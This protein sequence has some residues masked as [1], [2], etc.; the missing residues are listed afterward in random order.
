MNE[1]NQPS[2]ELVVWPACGASIGPWVH[3]QRN[4]DD[5]PDVLPPLTLNFRNLH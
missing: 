5:P 1:A 3:P 4:H 2:A